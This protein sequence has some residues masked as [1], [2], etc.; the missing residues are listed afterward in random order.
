MSS[1]IVLHQPDHPGLPFI[2]QLSIANH[3]RLLDL[4]YADGIFYLEDGITGER[5][6]EPLENERIAVGKILALYIAGELSQVRKER[7]H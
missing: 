4:Y 7:G 2:I 5:I 3:H 1:N 6:A